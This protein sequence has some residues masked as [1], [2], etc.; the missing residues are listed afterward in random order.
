MME[1]YETGRV[2]YPLFH[3]FI[4]DAASA[5]GTAY[6]FK[7]HDK[8]PGMKGLYRVL[9]KAVFKYNDNI[10]NLD[11]GNVRDLVRGGIIDTEMKGLAKVAEYI[12]NSTEVILC[13]VKD[14][15]NEPSPCGWTDLMINFYLN[16]DPNKHVCEVQ[17]IHF[18]MLSQ[19]TTQ[20]GHEA[21][22]IYR[23]CTGCFSYMSL[24]P[25]LISHQHEL[26][27]SFHDHAL[28]YSLTL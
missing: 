13:R 27:C 9:E 18:K 8:Q 24:K 4:A 1:L 23:V 28:L 7:S 20:E 2:A 12:L 5:S 25:T 15:F 22:N 17:L 3:A 10:E 14:R 21:Y 6:L 19:R 16:N 11:F 26:L